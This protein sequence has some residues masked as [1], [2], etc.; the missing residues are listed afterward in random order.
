MSWLPGAQ[1]AR[2][3]WDATKLGMEIRARRQQERALILSQKNQV[4]KTFRRKEAIKEVR[5]L[6]EEEN[7]EGVARALLPDI[8]VDKSFEFV[9]LWW[10]IWDIYWIFLLLR[11]VLVLIPTNSGYIHPDEHFQTVEVIIG[12]VMELETH[13]TWEFNVTAPLRSPTVPYSLYGVPLFFL[14]YVNMYF[15]NLYGW[16]FIGPFLLQL[17]PRLVM[18]MLS[19]TV[20]FTV[21]QICKLYKHSF[22]QCLTTLASSYIMLIYSTRTFSNS[23]ELALS[24]LLL[25]LV[26]HTIKR[27]DETVYLQHLVQTS[28]KEA[29]T[30]KEKVEI[31]KKR[32]LIPPHDFKFIIP[33]SLICA[34]GFFN[35]PTFVLFSFPPLFFW[36]QRG[37]SNKSVFTPFQMFNFR[38]AL[39]IPLVLIF[40]ALLILTDSLYYGQLTPIKLWNLTM[41]WEDWKVAPFNFIMYNIVPGNVVS[42]GEHP[43]YT[44]I[45]VNL[46]VLLGPL[47][48]IF[49]ITVLNWVSECIY[50]DWRHKPDVRNVF[51][52]TLM[53]SSLPVIGLSVI[54]HQ[55]PRF[56]IPILPSVILMCS[57]KLRWKCG[58]WKP[59]LT[60]WYAFNILAVVWFGF[61]HQAG[62][63]PL[64][65]DIGNLDH[66]HV[67]YV[68]LV[69]SH[70]Y[71]PPRYPLMQARSGSNNLAYTTNAD[72]KYL[73]HELGSED[74]NSVINRLLA[75]ISR[76]EYIYKTQKKQMHTYLIIPTHLLHQF[77][78]L[79]KNSLH[80]QLV[81]SQ[82]PHVSVE[83][84]DQYEHVYWDGDGSVTPLSVVFG[85]VY[86]IQQLSLSLVNVTLGQVSTVE[87][88]QMDRGG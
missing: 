54:K 9:S 21:Y 17:L 48:P 1:L 8:V 58:S 32:K 67:P 64:Q 22:N 12:D 36:F 40:G 38:I 88:D 53:S 13:R 10:S 20:D 16:N 39:L 2:Q 65:R 86:S 50:N 19:L 49:V 55:E 33:I 63:V 31:Q 70:T 72:T 25:Y 14:K 37:V 73:V 6:F 84:L 23:V 87:M 24:S 5:R 66:G 11:V 75:L 42:H 3:A 34:I 60:V 61:I 46:P 52:L 43:W 35:R 59:M 69:Y 85:S 82:A 81:S 28:Y 68:N 62:V 18:L 77:H 80:L 57:H 51:S 27:T 74:L 15:Y 26:A 71:M 79:A 56:L 44:H 83:A 7:Y 29:K 45:L 4:A 76:G 30:I 47:A 41:S 78:H